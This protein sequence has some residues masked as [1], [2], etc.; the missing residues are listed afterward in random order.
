MD[1]KVGAVLVLGGGPAGLQASLDLA[2][3]GYRVYLTE[4]SPSIGGNMA[5]LDKVFPTN[6][7]AM[8]ILGPRMSSTAGHPNIEILTNSELLSVEGEAGNFTA[9]VR[10]KAR[11]V[12]L[13]KCTS[14]GECY[15]NCLARNRIAV[16]EP[17]SV[18]GDLAV[19]MLETLDSF[20]KPDNGE[21]VTVIGVLQRVQSKYNYLPEEALRYVAESM[22]VRL[23]QIYALATFYKAFS[24]EPRGKHLIRVCVGTACHVRGAGRLVGAISRALD[25]EPGETTEDRQFTLETVNC[26][27]ACALAPVMMVDDRYFEKVTPDRLQ[28]ILASYAQPAE[29]AAG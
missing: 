24:L 29:A 2:D 18:R 3:A 16:P 5:R 4:R 10:Q 19:D 13:E 26:L 21:T 22:N 7:C 23:S 8:C 6:E 25:I 11:S 17:K 28:G 1:D 9:T 14:C 20:L 12:D 15:R 27:G